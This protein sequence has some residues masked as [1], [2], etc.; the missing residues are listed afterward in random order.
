MTAHAPATAADLPAILAEIR[1]RL[2]AIEAAGKS[3]AGRKAKSGM[4]TAD[5]V[6]ARLS[7]SRDFFD[8]DYRP[9][10]TDPRPAHAKGKR[11]P[12]LL[13]SDEVDLFIDQGAA[14]LAQYR[15]KKGRLAPHEV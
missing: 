3:A 9:L 4:V 7:I 10:F 11:K 5:E 15:R 6:A 13:L 12:V 8:T 14:A 1:D 2:A